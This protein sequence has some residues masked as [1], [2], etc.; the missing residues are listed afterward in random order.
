MNL[1]RRKSALEHT[2]SRICEHFADSRIVV[3][4]PELDQYSKLL[5]SVAKIPQAIQHDRK[6]LC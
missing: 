4:A 5:A 3:A 2:L 1:V 6:R